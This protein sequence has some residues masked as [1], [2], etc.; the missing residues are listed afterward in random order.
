MTEHMIDP[1]GGDRAV[2]DAIAAYLGTQPSWSG[3]DCLE[4]IS[5]AIGTVRPH[6]GNYLDPD[7]YAQ[8]FEAH[9]GRPVPHYYDMRVAP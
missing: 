7:V 4:V 3:A 5:D 6:P 2:V 9:T 1:A 8:A